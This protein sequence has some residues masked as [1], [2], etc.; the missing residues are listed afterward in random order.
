M[1]WRSEISMA[2]AP[3]LLQVLLLC[4]CFALTPAGR[5]GDAPEASDGTGGRS[6]PE[7]EVEVEE[8]DGR[9]ST[10]PGKGSGEH[11]NGE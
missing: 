11:L 1:E 6:S 7:V 5:D 8:G 3:L 2:S 4:G 9:T 10:G